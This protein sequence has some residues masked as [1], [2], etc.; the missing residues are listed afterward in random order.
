VRSEPRFPSVPQGSGH[1]ESFYVKAAAPG[2]GRAI[3]IRHTVHKRPGAAPTCAVWFVLFERQ[4]PR[5]TKA[6]FGAGELE[7]GPGR[8]LRID[9]AE[10]GPGF[11]RG[12][13]D[14]EALSARWDLSFRDRHE[15]LRHLPRD[16]MYRAPLPRTKL[17]SPHPG[18]LFT[19]GLELDGESI[20]LDG[21]AGMVGHN[22]GAE[23]AE[24]WIWLHG[25]ELEGGE[26]GDYLDLAAGRVKLGPLTSPWIA[27]G[28]LVLGGRPHQLGGL[29]RVR[30]T[31]V[32]AR[33][34]S[35]R[36]TVPGEGIT[37]HGRLEAPLEQ[38]VGW[39][40]ADPDGGE[41]NTI[42][43]SICDLEL[44]VERE[45]RRETLRVPAGAAYELGMRET[46][47][48]V[49]IQPYPDG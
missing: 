1:Y 21:W 29:G 13:I 14:T 49:P 17:L 37:V 24:R 25:G 2:G 44:D 8:Y 7:A 42:N 9:G 12:A 27:N 22:W 35:C 31:E 23:H 10:I 6:S 38:F 45:G 33:P 46:D 4:G 3:W 5:A 41:H 20:D 40:Y 16:W 36:F 39:I 30:A 26:P 34:G 28:R 15:T 19:G 47:H 11:V 32:D 43:C 18:A 48:G